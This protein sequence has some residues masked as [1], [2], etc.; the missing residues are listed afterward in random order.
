MLFAMKLQQLLSF[1]DLGT[2]SQPEALEKEVTGI[3]FDARQIEKSGQQGS[4]FVAIKGTQADG[5]KY[6]G[7]AIKAG[8]IA[9]VVE[10]KSAVPADYQG[11]VSVVPDSRQMLDLL[12]AR[13]YDYPSQKLFCFGVTGTN[14]KTSITYLL[15]HILNARGKSTGVIGTV[16]HRAGHKTWENQGT[17]PDPV[18]LQSRLNDFIK[19]GAIAAALEVT[20]HALDQRRADSVHFNTVIYTN[21]THDHLDYHNDMKSYFESKQ[22]LFTDLMW[23]SLKRPLFAIINIDDEYGRKL[24]LAEP[25][26]GWTYGQKESDFQFKILKMNFAETEFELKT[27]L[28]TIIV[29]VPLTGVHTIYNVVASLAAGLTCGVTLEQGIKALADFNGIPG[30][31]QKVVHSSDKTVFIDYA[32]TPDALENSLKSL[33]KVKTDAKLTSRVITVFGCGGDRDKTKRPKMAEIAA[34]LSDYV[35]LTSDNPRTEDPMTILSDAEK[36]FP[37]NFKNYTKEVDR[38]KAIAQAIAMAKPGDVILIAG[39]GHEDYQIMGTTKTH[40]SDY[41]VAEKYLG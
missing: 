16:N 22:R 36:G 8:A 14:G 18:T 9:L 5:H 39:K 17:T 38:E 34:R 30:R 31:L 25:V 40:F 20:S 29:K 23:S 27:P 3:F 32:H 15:E 21:L 19:E 1:S 26:L 11:H 7:D 12:A 13:F 41:E 2:Q 37:A 24:K 10:D 35:F 33:L 4:V 28:E 6:I